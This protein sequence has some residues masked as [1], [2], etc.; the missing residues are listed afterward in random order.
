V[1]LRVKARTID[2]QFPRGWIDDH[3]LTAADLEQ[4]IEFLKIA[5][6][7]ARLV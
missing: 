7:K 4:E 5:G 2:I 3:P 1:D 6:F